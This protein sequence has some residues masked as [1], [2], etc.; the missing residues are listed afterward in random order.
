[1][2]FH[3]QVSHPV[4]SS[5]PIWSVRILGLCGAPRRM[6][7]CPYTNAKNSFYNSL[8]HE[9]FKKNRY[10][11]LTTNH[12]GN[13]LENLFR[14]SPPLHSWWPRD[15]MVFYGIID[16]ERLSDYIPVICSNKSD[17]GL[18]FY[19][20]MFSGGAFFAR[21]HSSWHFIILPVGWSRTESSGIFCSL[22]RRRR[23]WWNSTIGSVFIWPPE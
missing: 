11:H 5:S 19:E 18:G 12:L 22:K 20:Q 9:T 17:I 7:Q 10:S 1:M 16:G 8:S 23:R 6:E 21:G 13:Y 3:H 15:D 14:Q 4:F 2:A